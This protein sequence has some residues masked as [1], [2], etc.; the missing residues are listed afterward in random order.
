MKGPPEWEI[1]KNTKV[2]EQVLSQGTGRTWTKN[3]ARGPRDGEIV[4]HDY[5]NLTFPMICDF[6]R[7]FDEVSLMK[8]LSNFS[9]VFAKD[10]SFNYY[11]DVVLAVIW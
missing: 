8:I 11:E 9:I 5:G 4:D 3:D 10:L 6:I 7:S 2:K 1:Q